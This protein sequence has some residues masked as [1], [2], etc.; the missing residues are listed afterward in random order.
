MLTSEVFGIPLPG[1]QQV[2]EH[3][4]AKTSPYHQSNQCDPPEPDENPCTRPTYNTSQTQSAPNIFT[5]ARK[6]YDDLMA[7]TL[8]LETLQ[9]SHI[10]EEITQQLVQDKDAMQDKRTAKL[11]LQYIDSLIGLEIGI[12][13]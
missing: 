5:V 8:S 7:G 6:L 4:D 1:T 10:V 11:L 12:C 3:N 13:I 9:D 2:I